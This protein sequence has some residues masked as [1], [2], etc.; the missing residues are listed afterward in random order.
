M[1]NEFTFVCSLFLDGG[2][3]EVSVIYGWGCNLDVLWK[4]KDI[5]V[6][7]LY[8]WITKS[9]QDG[10]YEPGQSDILIE[11]GELLKVKFCHEA[12]IHITTETAAI[13]EKCASR[14]LRQGYRVLRSNKVPPSHDSWQEVQSVENATA[15]L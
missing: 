6:A 1:V 8:D 7:N 12:D 15:G 13:I 9:I 4:P 3:A 11:A 14:W 5:A 10:V 2:P